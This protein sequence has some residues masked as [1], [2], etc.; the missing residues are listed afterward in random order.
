MPPIAILDIDGTL[1][2]TNYHHT[3]AWYR[4]FRQHGITL[5]LWKI[6]THIGMGGDQLVASLTSETVDEEKG[7]DIR[8]AEKALY[9]ALIEEVEPVEEAREFIADLH[10]RGHTVVLASSA[11]ADEVEHYLDLLDARSLADDWTTS[12]DVESTKPQP[13]LVQAALSKAGGGDAVMVGDTPWDIKAAAG[14]DV[15]TIAVITGGFSRAELEEA[16]AACVFES[17]AELRVAL[18][19]TPL[20]GAA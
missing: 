4:A 17:V 9:M 16:G 5:P 6:H 10:K 1:V 2:D 11:K 18:E 12:A 20:G 15:P 13:D 8:S 14:A 19:D 3:L 7:D